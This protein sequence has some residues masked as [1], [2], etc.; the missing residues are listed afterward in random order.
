MLLVVLCGYPASGKST[1][2]AA[3][4][5]RFAARGLR[6]DTVSDGA[7]H[8]ALHDPSVTPGASTGDVSGIL[9]VPRAIMY[10]DSHAEKSTRARLLAAAERALA[11]DTVVLVDSMNYIKGFRYEL[12]CVAKTC[13][14][15]FLV[16]HTD[17]DADVCAEW[18]SQRVDAYGPELH[19]ALVRRFEPPHQRNRW[20]SPLYTVHMHP[21][22]DDLSQHQAGENFQATAV[23]EEATIRDLIEEGGSSTS[24]EAGLDDIVSA[25]LSKNK[26]LKPTM[27]TKL[28]QA[29]DADV[30]NLLD[31]ATR[32][33]EAF[34]LQ[35]LHAGAGTG[36]AIKVPFATRPVFLIR[37]C[38][39]AELRGMRRAHINLA[40]LCPP[41]DTSKRALVD[42]Y[43]DYVNAQL[44]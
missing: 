6:V 20:D 35:S 40:R 14:A 32:D 36:D 2:A 16:V 26:A 29:G 27:A 34:L 38:R 1:L 13:T 44:R 7:L 33:A 10:A 25:S 12:F 19:A 37:R 22:R 24:W 17:A 31:Q 23:A 43:V 3:L 4:A 8:S 9:S 28:N 15:R 21:R 5:C 41:R 42:A 39:V 18:D 11:P 30:L